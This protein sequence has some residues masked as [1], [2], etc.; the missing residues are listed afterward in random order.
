M[1]S[2]LSNHESMHKLSSYVARVEEA[3]GSELLY[4]GTWEVQRGAAVPGARA[5]RL[6][7]M[8]GGGAGQRAERA[9]A[10]PMSPVRGEGPAPRLGRA[11]G[12]SSRG[13]RRGAARRERCCSGSRARCSRRLAVARGWRVAACGRRLVAARGRAAHGVLVAG[14]AARRRALGALSARRGGA[15]VVLMCSLAFVALVCGLVANSALRVF[16]VHRPRTSRSGRRRRWPRLPGRTGRSLSGSASAR[17]TRFATTASVVIGA[18]PSSASNRL[19][20]CSVLP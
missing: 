18:A 20:S 4:H 17:T 13:R 7:M 15:V 9:A 16:R 10:C 2:F 19:P 11:G 3:E 5:M 6:V 14:V 1:S 12:A 8:G